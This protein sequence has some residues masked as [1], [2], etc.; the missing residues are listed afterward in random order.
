MS[1]AKIFAIYIS[2]DLAIIA[3]VVWCVFQRIPVSRYFLP[4]AALFV[5]N[6]AW[7]LVMT[8]KATPPGNS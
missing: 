3:G 6:G 4:A 8:I 7:L 1:H 5:L 2:I